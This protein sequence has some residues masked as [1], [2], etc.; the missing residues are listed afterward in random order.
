MYFFSGDSESQLWLRFTSW[1]DSDVGG[2]G[3]GPQETQPRARGLMG[4]SCSN[5]E[6]DSVGVGRGQS[7]THWLGPESPYTQPRMAS[8]PA[9]DPGRSG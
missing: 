6:E 5:L 9:A 2:P 3:T 1:D 7:Q 8:G 4:Q